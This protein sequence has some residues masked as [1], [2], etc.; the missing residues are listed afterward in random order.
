MAIEREDLRIILRVLKARQ[1]DFSRERLLIL[2]NAGI[3]FSAL[4]MRRLAREEEFRLAEISDEMSPAALGQ[5]LGFKR[6]DTL[7]VNGKANITMDLEQPCPQSLL[8]QFDLIIDAGCFFGV[9][10]LLQP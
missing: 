4:D 9:S 1:R 6:T 5:A 7:D 10:I 2:G 8:G 3:L